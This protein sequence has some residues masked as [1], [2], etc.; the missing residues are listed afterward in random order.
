MGWMNEAARWCSRGI[1]LVT[2]AIEEVLMVRRHRFGRWG[3]GGLGV[4]AFAVLSVVRGVG[5]EK[6]ALQE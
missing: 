6:G 4:G 1:R 2:R 3:A 5:C